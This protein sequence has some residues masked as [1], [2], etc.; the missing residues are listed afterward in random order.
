MTRFGVMKH[1]Q[2]AR[3][4][5]PRRHPAARPGEAPLP[6]PR[7]HPARPRPVGEQ[8]RR[9][10]GRRAQ[11]P[12]ARDWRGPWRRSS[13]STSA[14]RP[15]RL[16]EAI[17]D[18]EIR[19]QVQL[20]RPAWTPTGRPARGFEMAH[21][22]PAGR[23]AR[24][25]SSRSTRRAGSCRRMTA[26]W[27]DEVKAEGTL[28]G[29]LGDRAGRATPCRLTVTHDQLREGANDQ[30]YGGWP[31]I[32]SGLKTWL[33][34]GE[35][36]TTPGLAD[37]RGLKRRRAPS[38]RRSG[39]TG[40]VRVLGVRPA[41]RSC[42]GCRRSC[43]RPSRSAARA[44]TRTAART[45]GR[46]RA[47]ARVM[48]PFSRERTDTLSARPGFAA[49]TSAL[50]SM[51]ASRPTVRT[52]ATMSRSRIGATASAST[53]SSRRRGRSAPRAR[54]CRCSRCP[55]RSTPRGR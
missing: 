42:R 34:T 6:E 10:V 44:S 25:R 21:P 39:R 3:G 14:P 38:G 50:N 2:G 49:S 19:A 53:G 16:W 9:A 26:L 32:L 4:R 31:M 51:P 36:L 48:T 24:A 27:S 55:P 52:S 41:A 1:L 40:P 46:R 45:A 28:A 12:Q 15:E 23:W 33:E 13:R 5:R 18:P 17:T 29:D 8:V 30:L 54:G 43:P 35:L 7:P 37:V 20:R 22:T 47:G 11:R